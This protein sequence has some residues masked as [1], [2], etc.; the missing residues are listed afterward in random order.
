MLSFKDKSCLNEW[1]LLERGNFLL[2]RAHV[3]RI[4]T[5]H[6]LAADESSGRNFSRN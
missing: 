5:K 2:F 1:L 3:S 4:A 6:R